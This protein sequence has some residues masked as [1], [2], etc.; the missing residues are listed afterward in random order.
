MGVQVVHDDQFGLF[1]GLFL[2]DGGDVFGG[3][4]QD[5]GVA[6]QADVQRGA[7]PAAGNDGLS[8]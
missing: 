2:G 7:F 6:L 5:L 4:V 8:M 3:D 1:P